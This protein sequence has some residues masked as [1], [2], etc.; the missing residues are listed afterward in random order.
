M[1]VQGVCLCKCVSECKYGDEICRDQ[2]RLRV[3]VDV[4]NIDVMN[5]DV[6]NFL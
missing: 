3:P 6:M 5:I 1:V 4:M 2:N